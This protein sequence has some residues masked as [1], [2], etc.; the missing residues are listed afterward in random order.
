[1][2]K[3]KVFILGDGFLPRVEPIMN[4]MGYVKKYICAGEQAPP[5]PM[6]SYKEII[7]KGD[8]KNVLVETADD[9]MAELMFTSGTT[10]APKPVCHS[11]DTLFYI[12]IGCALTYNEGYNSIYLAPHPF[13]HS[14][15]LFL[16]FP[17]Y[18]AG[19]KILMPMEIQPKHY[20]R[21]L[22]DE[23]CTGGWNTVPVWSDVINS[24]LSGE[25]KLRDYDLS[26]LTHIEI[27]LSP[28]PMSFWRI[29]RKSSR[30]CRWPI[31]M[32]SQRGAVVAHQPLRRR[33]HEKAGFHREADRLHGSQGCR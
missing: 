18:I 1:V 26:A 33:H 9:D 16:S 28:S 20:L 25:V 15:T 11:H 3:C 10:G 8:P 27:G 14:G 7:E 22:A 29:R 6:V 23:K 30:T 21:T 24:I 19:G 13:Y 4:E 2:T 32:G 12:G 31:S 5:S 17:S